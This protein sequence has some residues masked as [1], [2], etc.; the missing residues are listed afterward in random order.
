MQRARKTVHFAVSFAQNTFSS[1]FPFI[2]IFF[3]DNQLVSICVDLFIPSLNATSVTIQFLL[4]RFH[5]QP[6]ILH[7]CQSEIDR[8]VGQGRLP[9][10]NDR[11][12]YVFDCFI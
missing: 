6:E 12:K 4:Q 7:K 2:Y 1:M 5:F 3:T 8:V 9:T 11:I 10:L